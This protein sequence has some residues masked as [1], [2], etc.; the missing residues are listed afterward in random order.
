LRLIAM[1]E[2]FAFSC[3][4]SA[5][6]PGLPRDLHG[7]AVDFGH[8]VAEP[9]RLQPELVVAWERIGDAQLSAIEIGDARHRGPR[10]V[11]RADAR[12]QWALHCSNN[13]HPTMSGTF[14][15]IFT[16]R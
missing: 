2:E 16:F 14:I 13:R 4:P 12:T 15:T 1:C 9:V 8:P 5:A 6:S 7:A 3:G 11:W 10:I